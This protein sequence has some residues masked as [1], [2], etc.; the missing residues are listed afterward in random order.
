MVVPTLSI[1]STFSLSS[2]SYSKSVVLEDSSS[3]T[4]RPY[5]GINDHKNLTEMCK[6]V[7]GGTDYLP[8]I[9]H[10]FEA[11]DKCDF[12]V[13]EDDETGDLVAAGNRRIFDREGNT[14]W[15]E[16]IRAA[17]AY[18]GRGLA[19]LLLKEMVLRSCTEKRGMILSCTVENNVAMQRVF[20]RVDMQMHKHKVHFVDFDVM[21]KIPGWSTSSSNEEECIENP[22]NM[23]EALRLEHLIPLTAKSDKWTNV[24]NEED[25]R[26]EL[27]SIL[28]HGGI[29]HLPGLGKLLWISDELRHSMTLGL[30][31]KLDRNDNNDRKPCLFALVKD[32]AIQS[33][34]SKYVCSIVAFSDHDF[35]SAMYAACQDDIIDD[36]GV[37][38]NAFALTFD[39]CLPVNTN[40]NCLS[41]NLPLSENPFV[42]YSSCI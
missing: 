16:A 37:K 5:V 35:S 36:K 21:K 14:I 31:K 1:L 9:A 17:K 6:D 8:N 15:I 29:G 12:L 7:W 19:S 18:Q 27:D 38:I 3:Y 11:D 20:S 39:G 13:V 40:T 26:K 22:P 42:I 41:S 10:I 25:L 34:K 24:K 33:L 32:S 28:A 23:L 4:I 2:L 30:V